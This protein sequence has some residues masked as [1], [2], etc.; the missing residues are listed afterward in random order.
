MGEVLWNIV[1]HFRLL[2]HFFLI[3]KVCLHLDARR[4]DH[5]RVSGLE[6]INEL[7]VNMQVGL[8]QHATT[9]Q[10]EEDARG[11]L[12][13][14][15]GIVCR[16]EVL[17][18]QQVMELSQTRQFELAALATG[19]LAEL[20]RL[21]RAGVDDLPTVQGILAA[22][23]QELATQHVKVKVNIVADQV[24]RF[25]GGNHKQVEHLIER[26]AVF[27]GMFGRDAMNHLCIDGNDKAVGLH[28]IVVIFH[29]AAFLV[30]D[31]PS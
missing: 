9:D 29:E 21:L 14:G 20:S 24:F 11:G 4:L 30:M 5:I 27:H 26:F 17:A 16:V 13:I 7:N 3:I 8:I 6:V 18:K 28:K 31:L 1:A 23:T 15:T 12:H 2:L 25:G 10:F 22:A 19:E